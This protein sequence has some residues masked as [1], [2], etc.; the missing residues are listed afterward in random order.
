MRV[1]YGGAGS[2]DGKKEAQKSGLRAFQ[3][4]VFSV[5]ISLN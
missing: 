5:S 2:L 1:S 3:E 4:S